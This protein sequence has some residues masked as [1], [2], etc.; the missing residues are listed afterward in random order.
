MIAQMLHAQDRFMFFQDEDWHDL[1]LLTAVN[2][3]V[4]RN[5]D[6]LISPSSDTLLLSV[7]I[8][9]NAVLTTE[10]KAKNK[11]DRE[12]AK[13]ET[14][15]EFSKRQKL[16]AYIVIKLNFGIGIDLFNIHNLLNQIIIG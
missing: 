14:G 9:K 5:K 2:H 3:T 15:T 12:Q 10:Q 11:A 8:L 16:W 4:V 1:E 13:L 6:P 7:P